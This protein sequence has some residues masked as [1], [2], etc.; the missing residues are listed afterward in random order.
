MFSLISAKDGLLKPDYAD[1]RLGLGC[2]A[3]TSARVM[4]EF[5]SFQPRWATS[6]AWTS[7][8]QFSASCKSRIKTQ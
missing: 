3:A 4:L 5:G 6:E 1:F 2:C 7:F 8:Y